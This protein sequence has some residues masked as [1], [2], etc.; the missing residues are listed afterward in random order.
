MVPN[1]RRFSLAADSSSKMRRYP[2]RPA[3]S[4]IR[5]G[6]LRKRDVVNPYDVIS[7]TAS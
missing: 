4:P 3:T 1:S 6:Q 7:Q 5:L 2:Q